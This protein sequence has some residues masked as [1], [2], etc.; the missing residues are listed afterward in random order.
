M[1]RV[2]VAEDDQD[3]ARLITLQLR[4]QGY[5]V[6]LAEDGA[7][8]LSLARSERPD[9]ILLD[10]MMPVMDGLETM[11]VLKADPD[12]SQIPVIMMTAKARNQDIQTGLSAGAAAYLV[13]PFPLEELS[14][15]IQDVL[16]VTHRE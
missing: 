1:R 2:L 7:Q 16:R 4:H 3:I 15:A 12:L 8:A 13:K 11:T 10:W 14:S 9:V 5:Q 6:R